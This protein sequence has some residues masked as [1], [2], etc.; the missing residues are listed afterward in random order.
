MR[1]GNG[2]CSFDTAPRM[3]QISTALTGG[4]RVFLKNDADDGAGQWFE[5]QQHGCLQFA[6]TN[7]GGCGIVVQGTF[8]TDAVFG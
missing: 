5:G 6:D 4:G 3:A 8:Q 2:L 7:P 1:F